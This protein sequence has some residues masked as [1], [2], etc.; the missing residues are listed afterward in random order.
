[1]PERHFI[2][3]EPDLDL[4]PFVREPAS[5][6]VRANGGRQTG[7]VPNHDCRRGTTSLARISTCSASYR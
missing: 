6:V 1:M 5:P 2:R 7:N 4:G 3:M